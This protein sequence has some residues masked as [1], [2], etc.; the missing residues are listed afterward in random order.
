MGRLPYVGWEI[1]SHAIVMTHLYVF[2]KKKKKKEDR[3]SSCVYFIDDI[4]LQ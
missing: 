2:Q 4:K 1:S 3:H